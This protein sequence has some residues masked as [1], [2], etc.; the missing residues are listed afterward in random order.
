M[1]NEDSSKAAPTGNS[2]GTAPNQ[3]APSPA[4]LFDTINAYQRTAV[5]KAAVELDLF[6]AMAGTPA[7]AETVAAHCQGSPRG[8]RILCDYLTVLG[9]LT[10]SEGRY[11]LTPDSALFLNRKSPAFAGGTLKFLLADEIKG[12]FDHF[13]DAARTG[14]TAQSQHGTLA[15]E[16]PVWISFA[17]SMGPL[18]VQAANGLAELVALDPDRATK[19]LDISA[20]HGMW[21]IAFARKSPKT[22]LVALDWSPVLE[23][24]RE[25]ARAA[26]VADQFS[27]VPGSAFDVEFGTDYD[28]VLVPNFLHHFNAVDCVRLLKKAHAALRPGGAVAIVEFVPNPDRITPPAAAGFSLI[29]LATTPEGDAYTFA[30]YSDMLAQAGFNPPTVH[31]LPAS[32]NVAVI[33]RR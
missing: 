22:R 6:T 21:G 1:T 31:S 9:F 27:T 20:S 8:I 23:V 26:G 4:L 5:I 7:T 28:I 10:K 33:A 15:P 2:P 25:N 30:E 19:V 18:M 24:A 17:R 32:M 16:H 13:T 12:A 29:M 14:G 11:A 3:P